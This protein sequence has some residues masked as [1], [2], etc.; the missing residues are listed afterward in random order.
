M[1][2][3]LLRLIVLLLPFAFIGYLLSCNTKANSVV[4]NVSAKPFEKL[5]DYHFFSGV[6][7]DLIPNARVAPYDL[8]TPLFSDYAQKARFIYMPEGQ[9]ADYDTTKVL[10]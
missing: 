9:S 8:I 7:S 4:L 2:P 10:A 3:T 1:K 5:S 6:M